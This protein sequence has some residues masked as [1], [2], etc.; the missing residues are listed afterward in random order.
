VGKANIVGQVL[1][2]T[3]SKGLGRKNM[4]VA[5]FSGEQGTRDVCRYNEGPKEKQ[6]VDDGDEAEN[7]CN[8]MK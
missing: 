8:I 7:E 1:H 2:E 4:E 3:V 6:R 5:L